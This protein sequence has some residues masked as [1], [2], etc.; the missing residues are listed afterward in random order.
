M[1]QVL[2]NLPD[3]SSFDELLRE[4]AFL[5]MIERG[6]V[7]SDAGDVL[8]NEEMQERIRSWSN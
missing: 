3:D 7:D 2:Q 6:I 8:S 5:R 4:L 1:I